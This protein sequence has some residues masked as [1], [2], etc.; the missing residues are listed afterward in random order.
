MQQNWRSVLSNHIAERY[1]QNLQEEWYDFRLSASGLLNITIVSDRFADLPLS[2]RR[3]QIRELLRE[4]GSPTSTGFLS[5][6]TIS[7]AETLSL[8]KPSIEQERKIDSWSDLAQEAMNPSEYAQAQRR[9]PRIPYTVTFYSFKGGVGRTTALIHVAWIL[10]M[11]G[12]KV[13]AVDLDLEALGLSALPNLTPIP[14]HGIVDYFYE[15]SYIPKG[16]EP[17]VSIVD[18]FGEVRIPNAPG[19][20]FIVPTGSL[21]LN[22]ITKLDDLRASAVTEHGEDLWSVFFREITEQLQPDIIL[23]DSRTGINEWGA[24]SL[25]RAA[26]QAIVFLYPNEQNKRGIDLLLEAFSGRVSLQLVFSPVPFGDAG[27]EKVK[28]YWQALQGRLDAATDHFG[29]GIDEEIQE[30]EAL[31]EV[32]EPI[33]INYFTEIAL[34]SNYPVFSFLSNYMNLANVVDEDTFA[35]SLE[36]VLSDGDRRRSLLEGLTLPAVNTAAA[37][38]NLRDLF[39]RTADFERFLDNTTSLIRGQKGTGK[40]TLY[41]LLL[42]HEKFARELSYKRLDH[43]NC[44]SGHDRLGPHPTIPDFQLIHQSVKQ[45]DGSWQAFWRSYL[46]LRMY[47]ENRL[48]PFKE[49]APAELNQLWSLLDEVPRGINEWQGEHTRVLVKMATDRN[50][51]S[52]ARIATDYIDFQLRSKREIFWFLYDDLDKDLPEKND[53]RNEALTAL[54]QLVKRLESRTSIR[55]KIFLREDIWSRL[56]FDSKG[57]F[58][59]RDIILQWTREDFLCLTLR[60]V[61]H[62]EKFKDLVDRLAPVENIDQADEASI[63]RALQLLWGVRR[64]PNSRSQYVS[65]WIYDRLTDAS[66]TTFPGS[67]NVLLTEAK[68]DALTVDPDQA[69]PADRLLPAISLHEGLLQASRQRCREV[70]DEYPALRSFFDALA[71]LE[72]LMS[73]QQLQELWDKNAKDI[74]PDSS[75]FVNFLIDIGLVRLVESRGKE[76]S[77]QF[78]EIYASGFNMRGR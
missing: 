35:V 11:R 14:E 10:A 33:T 57:H 44:L 59:G 27:M 34:A 61:L 53:L 68:K 43:V 55:F 45:D 38:P 72:A 12:R 22:Y 30:F 31:S 18:I 74:F 56:V 58:N 29:S 51:N 7:E 71:N 48:Q 9:K 5:L 65:R 46:L 69:L 75:D 15:R 73:K 2:E 17:N 62:S 1:I 50:L 24:F 66:G 64:E 28:E 3:K 13:V 23:V 26:D 32:A 40:T 41:E 77:Y 49:E 37:D 60:Q 47:L 76:Q 25:L 4:S 70:R 63:D 16:V 19:R 21:N 8:S 67:V 54:F 78:A 39:Q 52:L 36:P 6:Y 20:L 42:K